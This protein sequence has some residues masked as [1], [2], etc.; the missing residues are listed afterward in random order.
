MIR[1]LVRSLE[2]SDDQEDPG[3]PES[4]A[5]AVPSVRLEQFQFMCSP[6]VWEDSS[7]EE[8]RERTRRAPVSIG[9]VDAE[10]AAKA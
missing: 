7:A 9:G 2:E 1:G 4:D 3:S 5:G 8:C 6:G 10:R